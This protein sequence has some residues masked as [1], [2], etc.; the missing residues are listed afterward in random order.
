MKNFFLVTLAVLILFSAA[1][2]GKKTPPSPP[3]MRME[4]VLD[5]FDALKRSDHK[6][7][8]A[9]IER[10]KAI[11]RTN[12]FLSEF[13]GIERA[14]LMLQVAEKALIRNDRK[15]AEEAVREAIRQV[16]NVSNLL[17]ASEDIRTI[18]EMERL[19]ELIVDPVN[20]AALQSDINEF[21]ALAAKFKNNSRILAFAD[22]HERRIPILKLR[23]HKITMY[24]M[25]AD[26]LFFKKNASSVLDTLNSQIEI[27]Q[28]S[29]R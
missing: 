28:N 25:E 12:V 3:T 22:R 8:I 19:A 14:N 11:D 18:S 6:T 29:F 5:I 1:S 17:K 9:K 16:G 21:R 13:E 2:C 20:S 24:S 27:E 4:I 15:R 7:V 23:E 10:L 26:A